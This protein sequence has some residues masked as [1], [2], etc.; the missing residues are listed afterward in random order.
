MTLDYLGESGTARCIETALHSVYRKGEHLTRDLG[1][2]ASTAEF[3]GAVIAAIG[4]N[5]PISPQRG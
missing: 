2:R 4:K 5:A 3:T 1:G